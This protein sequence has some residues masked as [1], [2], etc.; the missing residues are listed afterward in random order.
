MNRLE[1][2]N[3]LNLPVI[4]IMVQILDKVRTLCKEYR[5]ETMPAK[6]SPV[7]LSNLLLVNS[8]IN[9]SNGGNSEYGSI[10]DFLGALDELRGKIFQFQELQ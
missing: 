2:Q 6:I 5:L 3:N 1:F 8:S 7:Q 10:N 4:T 9:M